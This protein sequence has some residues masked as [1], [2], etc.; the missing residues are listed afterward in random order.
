MLTM[1]C[2][3]AEADVDADTP[4]MDAGLDSLGAV[5]LRNQLQAAVGEGEDME[6]P[7]R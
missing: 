5:E 7:A 1:L 2:E 3:T 6:L 4:L